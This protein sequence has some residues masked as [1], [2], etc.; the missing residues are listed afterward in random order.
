MTVTNKIKEYASGIIG[1]ITL[2]G[3][4]LGG[5]LSIDERYAHAAEIREV[6]DQQ[7]KQIQR[8]RVDNVRKFYQ[9]RIGDIEQRKF[10]VEIK[11]QKSP[12]DE[13]YINRYQEQIQRLKEEEKVE[14]DMIL[15]EQ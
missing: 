6:I 4:I 2:I 8:L 9:G 14:I 11:T 7:S 3:V 10:D 15:R 5:F 13:I 12:V 1:S